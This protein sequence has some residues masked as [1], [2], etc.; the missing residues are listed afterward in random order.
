MVEL[1]LY[2]EERIDSRY[3]TRKGGIHSVVLHLDSYFI[4][5]MSLAGR[6]Y[7]NTINSDFPGEHISDADKV[8]HR[9][10]P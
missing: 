3:F 6:H 1:L 2:F 8:T 10:I 4:C 9:G 7:T 5:W